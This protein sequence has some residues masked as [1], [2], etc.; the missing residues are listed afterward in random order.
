VASDPPG[1]FSKNTS[2]LLAGNPPPGSPFL[3]GP[4]HTLFLLRGGE[5]VLALNGSGEPGPDERDPGMAMPDADP[6]ASHRGPGLMLGHPSR[7]ARGAVVRLK[8][9]G[10]CPPPAFAE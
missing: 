8:I 5:A 10:A 2:R 3:S 9:V 1:P 7:S 4:G 6:R